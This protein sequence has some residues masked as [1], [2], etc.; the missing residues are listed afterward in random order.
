MAELRRLRATVRIEIVDDEGKATLLAG[1]SGLSEER[2]DLEA[3][4]S[5][6][7]ALHTVLDDTLRE[8]TGEALD[9]AVDELA[10]MASA[11]R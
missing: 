1:K 2:V 3:G 5:G 7:R 11:T 9:A 4:V 10:E 8:V 6:A